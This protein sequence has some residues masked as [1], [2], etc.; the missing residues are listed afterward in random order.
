MKVYRTKIPT[1]QQS[2]Q[3]NFR[4][5]F[6]NSYS[7]ARI[8]ISRGWERT[9]PVSQDLARGVAGKSKNIP[10]AVKPSRKLFAYGLIVA[11]IVVVGAVWGLTLLSNISVVWDSFRGSG[12][13]SAESVGRIVGAPHLDSLPLTINKSKIAITGD[14]EPGAVVTIYK[15]DQ[16][17]ADQLV[18]NDGKFSF[19]DVSLAVGENS[20]TAKQ[21]ADSSESPDSNTISVTLDLTPPKL[22]VDKPSDGAQATGGSINVS[23]RADVNAYVFINDHQAVVAQD[24]TYN[25][26]AVFQGD[27]NKVVVTALDDAGNKTTVTR[28]I[29]R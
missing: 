21:S 18:G 2:K 10:K 6:E 7:Q 11:V 15:S 28:S 3:D 25:G 13:A 14:G 4:K 27:D 12:T 8:L 1:R 16:K 29:T 20:F 23:G 19:A 22:S 9:S 24:G 26:V 17:V 5:T